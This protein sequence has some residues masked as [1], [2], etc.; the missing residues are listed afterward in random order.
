MISGAKQNQTSGHDAY[1]GKRA[2]SYVVAY[3]NYRVVQYRD[4]DQGMFLFVNQ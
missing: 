3:E 4:A 1:F 2:L